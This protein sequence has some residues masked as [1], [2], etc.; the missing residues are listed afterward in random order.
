MRA[1]LQDHLRWW[2][3]VALVLL[4]RIRARKIRKT[5]RQYRA[6][7][8]RLVA[9]YELTPE[10]PILAHGTLL[11]S[12]IDA[13]AEHSTEPVR[14]AETSGSTGEPKRIAYTRTR[15]KEV[16]GIY[17]DA[18]ARAY[19]AMPVKR[20]SLY[21]LS[22]LQKDSSLT[23]LMMEESDALPPYLSGLQA[24]YR[25]QSHPDIQALSR[26]FGSHAVRT[27]V[28]AIS[29]PGVLYCTNPSTLST[30]LDAIAEDWEGVSALVRTA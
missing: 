9:G 28:L 26:E 25:V 6:N 10:R 14:F 1:W 12:E 17:I 16:V 18:F 23:T 15:L 7:Q 20:K 19:A 4:G 3:G 2:I 30:Y 29:N 22:S 27:W 11:Q 5:I 24:P 13:F 21:V 8:A